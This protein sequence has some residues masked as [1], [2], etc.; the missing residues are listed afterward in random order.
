[1]T[2]ENEVRSSE[3]GEK[4]VEPENETNSNDVPEFP[5]L[6]PMA[7]NRIVGKPQHLDK[8]FGQL[9]VIQREK[10]EFKGKPTDQ[11]KFYLGEAY[12]ERKEGIE[13][14]RTKRF[15]S[16]PFDQIDW[17]REAIDPENFEE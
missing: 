6:E 10:G 2:T 5:T 16:I 12:Y 17:L 4:M 11:L 1:M 7:G 15:F 3:S 8:G 9:I 13:K 14:L